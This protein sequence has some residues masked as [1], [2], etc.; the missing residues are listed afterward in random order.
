MRLL[1]RLILCTILFVP[2][3]ALACSLCGTMS[4]RV[5][6]MQEFEQAQ[7][8]V[9]GH[10]ANPKLDFKTGSGTTEFHFDKVVKDDPGFPRQKMLVLSRYL[11]VLDPKDAPRYVM[12]FRVPAKSAEPY[13]G[14]QISAPAVLEFVTRLQQYRDNPAELV[15]VAA[16][17]LD[18]ADPQIAEEAFLVFA[19]ADDKVIGQTAKHLSAPMLR[20][21]VKTPDL[22]PERLSMFAYLLGACGGEDDVDLLRSLLKNPAPRYF[23]AYEGILAGYITMRPQ[24]GWA[25]AHETLKSEKN[26]F[27]LRYAVLRAMRFFYNS[28]PAD[29][30]AQV[31]VGEGLAIAHPDIADVAIQ[32]LMRWKRWEHTKLIVSFYDKESHKSPIVK[33]SLVRYA[34]ACPQPE[35]RALVDRVRRQDPELVRYLEEE[36]K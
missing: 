34:L 16:K 36:L 14:R 5:S 2:C 35:A 24:E 29:N 28:N 13:N 10:L 21:L 11:P 33:N 18:D 20:K 17:H 6:L 30:A 1:S 19:K 23:R 31:L 4:R 26:S 12:F 27:V 7:V 9:Y 25:F 32:D 22:E 8:V 15:R 3:P